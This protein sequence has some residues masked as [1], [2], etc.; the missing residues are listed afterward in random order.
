M[1]LAARSSPFYSFNASFARFWLTDC[2]YTCGLFP[3]GL[4]FFPVVA[5]KSNGSKFVFLSPSDENSRRRVQ[6]D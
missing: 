1:P 4:P 2:V 3:A 6:Y 5:E